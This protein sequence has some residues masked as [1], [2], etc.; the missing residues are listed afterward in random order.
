MNKFVVDASFIL[1]A[2]L[3]ENKSVYIKFKELFKKTKSNQVKILAPKSIIDE[4]SNAIRYSTKDNSE[5]QSI[6]NDFLALP[7]NFIELGEVD[8]K[9][10]IEIAYLQNTTV[11]DTLYHVLS[12]IEN[13]IFLTCDEKYYQKAKHLGDIELIK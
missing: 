13:A 7:I 6:F 4:I 10:T 12:K 11:Y 9:K 8:Y 1:K 2:I 5:A 3:K